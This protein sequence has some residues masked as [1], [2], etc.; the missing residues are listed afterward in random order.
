LQWWTSLF[1]ESPSLEN[2]RGLQEV[3]QRLDQWDPL[4]PDLIRKLEADQHWDL[5]IE[6]AL[7][8]GDVN[9][10]IDLLPRQRWGDRDLQVAQAAETDH[11][12]AAI[13]IY[14]RCVDRLIEAR[15]RGNY[16]EAASILQRVKGLYHQFRASA[17]W[18]QFLT[19]LRQQHARLP[20]LQ[21]ELDRA[22]L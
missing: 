6:I 5:L 4:R 19:E 13:E 1:R 12:Q 22:G 9:R 16:Q 15:G 8:E 20:A 7:D 11:P 3:A 2:Y 10:A 17:E 21:D 18:D 14:C